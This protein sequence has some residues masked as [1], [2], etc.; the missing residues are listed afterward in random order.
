ML[1]PKIKINLL[2]LKA[3]LYEIIEYGKDIITDLISYTLCFEQKINQPRMQRK[4]THTQ[5]VFRIRSDPLILSFPDPDP[6]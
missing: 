2:Y 4:H 5:A 1:S 3:F 6:L